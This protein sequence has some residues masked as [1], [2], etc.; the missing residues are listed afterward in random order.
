MSRNSNNDQPPENNGYDSD[1]VESTSSGS[2]TSRKYTASSVRQLQAIKGNKESFAVNHSLTLYSSTYDSDDQ[3]LKYSFTDK[4][5]SAES[6]RHKGLMVNIAKES[7]IDSSN[8]NELMDN[9][10]RKLTTL[11]EGEIFNPTD[12]KLKK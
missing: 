2:I 5:S 8:S 1:S 12:A 3:E 4:Y 7:A 6:L 11:L 9:I 10:F